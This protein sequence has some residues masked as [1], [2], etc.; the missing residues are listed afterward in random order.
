M[1]RPGRIFINTEVRLTANFTDDDGV[2]ADPETVTFT[3]KSPSGD[4]VT[5]TY[6]TDDNL[7]RLDA[8]D[9][10]CDITPNESGRWFWRWVATGAGTTVGTEGNFIVDYSPHFD[11]SRDAYR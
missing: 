10:Y 1:M 11:E 2:D 8:G 4:A 7:G 3:A 6:L 5:Y 9:F